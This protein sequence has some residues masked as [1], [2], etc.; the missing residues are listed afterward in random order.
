MNVEQALQVARQHP[1]SSH[2]LVNGAGRLLGVIEREDFYQFI[3]DPSTHADSPVSKVPL[4]TLPTYKRDT[5]VAAVLEGLAR[6]GANKAI[7]VDEAQRPVGVITILD[8]LVASCSIGEQGP[9]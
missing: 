9:E 4:A 6:D 3:K 8:V 5:P 2:P 1:R 7:V